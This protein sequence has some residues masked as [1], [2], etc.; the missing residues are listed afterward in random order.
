MAE[1]TLA[2]KV[3]A[4]KAR[5]AAEAEAKAKQQ[6]DTP[7]TTPVTTP[8]ATPA[9]ATKLTMAE[10][11]AAAKKR[12][13]DKLNK[14]DGDSIPSGTHISVDTS[15]MPPEVADALNPTDAPEP[16]V[17]KAQ[18]DK[19]IEDS[20]LELETATTKAEQQPRG[21][22][23]INF[24]DL[25]AE[26][27]QAVKLSDSGESFCLIGPAG[28]GKTT[29]TRCI[30]TT[31]R[32]SGRIGTITTGTKNLSMGMPSI[33]FVS[34]TN[35]AV[36]NI[37]AAL[38][39]EFKNC[40]MTV[41][42][43]LEFVPEFY[44]D[45]NEDGVVTKHMEFV[46][47]YGANRA[48]LPESITHVVVEEGGSVP[49][50]LFEEMRCALP[51]G[52]VFIF[53]GDLN[54]LP[55]A[56]DDGILGYKLVEL[57]QNIVELKQ[58]YRAALLSPITRLAHRVLK[59]VP[60]RDSEVDTYVEESDH[61]IL[62]VTR[63]QPGKDP[64]LMV[65]AIGSYFSDLVRTGKFVQG[66]DVLLCPFNVKFGTIELNKYIAQ[67]R[68]EIDGNPTYEVAT[69]SGKAFNK[70]YLAVGDLV[71]FDRRRWFID[72]IEDNKMYVGH[73]TKAPTVNMNR[74]GDSKDGSRLEGGENGLHN[75]LS[76]DAETADDPEIKLQASHIITLKSFAD[77]DSGIT[78][79]LSTTGE[80]N[81]MYLCNALTVHKSQGSEWKNVYLVL[82]SSHAIAY[83]RELLYTGITRARHCL[84]L[85]YEGESPKKLSNSPFMKGITN[86]K[87]KGNDLASKI[88]YFKSKIK[89]NAIKERLNMQRAGSAMVTESEYAVEL[90][91]DYSQ[92]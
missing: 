17:T 36:A 76:L 77:D 49:L 38:P 42:H 1:L 87:I 47:T 50:W 45:V 29:T 85:I 39:M 59:G 55:P 83:Y 46:P 2:E 35:V 37:K 66:R 12:A 74:W 33:L 53:L 86:Q 32:D 51:D 48:S 88:N 13:M 14:V 70:H 11:L 65:K 10:I 22:S 43:L 63:M 24:A 58:V 80:V 72:K 26:Q 40:C 41:H 30:A 79:E 90:D 64:E 4:V 28:T 89:A 27:R 52:V 92:F 75:I 82:H 68:A 5:L 57:E 62:K 34:Y 56:F 9:S 44:E 18:I 69:Q 73:P 16:V 78:V 54:Q 84:T 21:K 19:A 61:G 81:A 20:K 71:F 67:A 91:D 25:N 31:L 60:M 7:V 6:P 15:K 3:A 23:D 8:V